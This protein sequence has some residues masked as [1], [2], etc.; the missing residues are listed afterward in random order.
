MATIALSD[1]DTNPNAYVGQTTKIIGKFV[2]KTEVDDQGS[3][4]AL[5]EQD[6]LLSGVNL[7]EHIHILVD[8]K[9]MFK[10]ELIPYEGQ[11]KV[12]ELEVE[13]LPKPPGYNSFKLVKILW[14]RNGY[15]SQKAPIPQQ[16]PGAGCFGKPQL[17]APVYQPQAGTMYGQQPQVNQ[18]G[19]QQAPAQQAFPPQQVQQGYLP[20]QRQY[21]A[22]PIYGFEG[23]PQLPQYQQYQQSPY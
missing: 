19:Q 22:P 23:L 8:S 7:T 9:N 11:D 16:N 15:F 14:A 21:Q 18:W 1:Y 10:D 20:Q 5:V 12:L 4:D 17:Q 6:F 3:F 2:S 13:I